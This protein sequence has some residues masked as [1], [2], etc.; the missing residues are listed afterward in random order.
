MTE[1]KAE[2]KRGPSD[3]RPAAWRFDR[4]LEDCALRRKKSRRRDDNP[5]KGDLSRRPASSSSAGTHPM[6]RPPRSSETASISHFYRRCRASNTRT[7][8]GRVRLDSLDDASTLLHSYP[9]KFES[10]C[11]FLAETCVLS[12]PDACEAVSKK[13]G[14]SS[15]SLRA[16]QAAGCALLHRFYLS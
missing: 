8:G 9:Q 14:G 6:S 5:E 3:E 13:K 1:K 2:R 10:S 16:Q 12:P 4:A 11:S 7:V 15:K